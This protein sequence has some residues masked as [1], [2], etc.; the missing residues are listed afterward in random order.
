M[1]IYTETLRLAT[2]LSCVFRSWRISDSSESRLHGR[3]LTFDAVF[4]AWELDV[5][6]AGID[7]TQLPALIEELYTWY[8]NKV[9]VA[10]DDPLLLT[11]VSLHRDGVVDIV[12][13]DHVGEMAFARHV[14]QLVTDFLRMNAMSWRLRCYS[15]TCRSGIYACTF[16]NPRNPEN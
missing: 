14:C 7:K 13:M 4:E 8:S 2:D 6:K 11:F 5:N 1:H 3:L 15:V 10:E 9:I 12:K 16:T